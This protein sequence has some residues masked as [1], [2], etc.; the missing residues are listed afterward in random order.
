[1]ALQKTVKIFP[2]KTE[3][4]LDH[5]I[6]EDRVHGSL[7][8]NDDLFEQE[9]KQI[10]YGGWV[11]VGHDSEIPS[12]GE[13]QRRTIGREEVIMVRQKDDSIAVLSNRCAHRGNLMCIEKSG[14]TKYLTCAYHGWVYGLDGKLLDIPH[15]GGFPGSKDGMGL[16]AVRTEIYRGFVFSSFNEKIG[17]LDEHLGKA[18]ELIDRACDMSPTGKIRLTAGWVK[19]RYYS[20]WK[21]LPENDTDG[22][23]VNYVHSSFARVVDSHYDNSAIG[24]E[25]S[26]VSQTKDW[27]DGHTEL[28]LSPSYKNYFEWLGVKE[29]RY[30]EYVRQMKD[31]FGDERGDKILRDGPPHAAI[32]P[33]LFLGEMNIVVF[34][35]ISAHECIQW[36]TPMLLDGAPDDVNNRILRQS[37][38][39]LGP[40]AF[41][42]ADDSVIS[43]RQQMALRD[44]ADWLDVS[45]GLNRDS[46]D[47]HGVISGHV[48]D[49]CTNRGFWR[50]YKKVMQKSLPQEDAQ[51]EMPACSH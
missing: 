30:P 5:L 39:A 41:L 19:Q 27:G 23:H 14:K 22:Y 2:V 37:E 1:M 15:P 11:F 13:Y 46:V 17:P 42:L 44:R 18:R 12:A 28:Y 43:E 45:R 48:T 9:M 38:A 10:F 21:M 24:N 3:I 36:H 40:S 29:N 50:H 49:E 51:S 20:N 32:F 6:Q 47:E 25:E 34:E 33:N 7:Y 35:P 16:K 31:S 8:S 26:L 4:D